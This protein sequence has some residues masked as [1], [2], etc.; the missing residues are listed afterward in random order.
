MSTYDLR[1]LLLCWGASACASQEVPGPA[2]DPSSGVDRIVNL[3]PAPPL[4]PVQ[5][6]E[7]PAPSERTLGNGLRL[8][9]APTVGS[10]LSALVLVLPGG[11]AD[12]PEGGGSTLLSHSIWLGRNS[13]ELRVGLAEKLAKQGSVYGMEVEPDHVQLA[14]VGLS[15]NLEPMIEFL[16]A[17]KEGGELKYEDFEERRMSQLD[18]LLI[19]DRSPVARGLKEMRRLS[20]SPGHPYGRSL[21]GDRK[22]L[23]GLSAESLKKRLAR[24]LCP[25]EAL[26]IG[27]GGLSLELVSRLAQEHLG[28]WRPCPKRSEVKLPEVSGVRQEVVLVDAPRRTQALL[29][30]SIPVGDPNPRT[31]LLIDVWAELLG[32]TLSSRLPTK[33]RVEGALTYGAHTFVQVDRGAAALTIQ[34]AVQSDGILTALGLINGVLA[35]TVTQAPSPEETAQAW[36]RLQVELRAIARDPEALAMSLADRRA[37]GLGAF[38]VDPPSVEEL[39]EV[40]SREL[41]PERAQLVV[42]GPAQA[43]QEP[44]GSAGW[45]PVRVVH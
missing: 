20:F 44:L 41:R 6:G 42:I 30:L 11:G 15:R 31:R 13:S 35:S 4:P 12:E 17:V 22:S 43:L 10:K 25:N 36:R 21:Y 37:A 5:L 33:L 26:L 18:E 3:P 19:L 38:E 24:S 23:G 40:A 29:L 14:M 28:D 7:L 1:W 9:V 2:V 16:T 45:G 32:G 39:L 27:T 8:V 34:T